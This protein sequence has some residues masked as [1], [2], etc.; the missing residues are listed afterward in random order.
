MEKVPL[1]S[2]VVAKLRDLE[3]FVELCDESGQARAV[4][5]PPE[6]HREMMS[7]WLKS[8]FTDEEIEEARRE[9]GGMT[10]AEAIAYLQ[11]VASEHR[12]I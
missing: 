12:R 9:S 7:A 4:A 2:D 11:K 10:T 5:M 3:T 1:N 8:M 6:L